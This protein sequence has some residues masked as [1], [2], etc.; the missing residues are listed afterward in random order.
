MILDH[1]EGCDPVESMQQD[2]MATDQ[3]AAVE[4]NLAY[5][6]SGEQYM[7]TQGVFIVL[8]SGVCVY[9]RALIINL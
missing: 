6:P 9:C 3:P 2:T 5:M 8:Y 4:T 1:S 7:D